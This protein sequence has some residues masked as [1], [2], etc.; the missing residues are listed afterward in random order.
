MIC[1][2][3]HLAIISIAKKPVTNPPK[4]YACS[5]VRQYIKPTVNPWNVSMLLLSQAF[6]RRDGNVK[7]FSLR[8]RKKMLI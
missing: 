3:N 8:R 6:N 4:D 1:D 5:F 7:I 2:P